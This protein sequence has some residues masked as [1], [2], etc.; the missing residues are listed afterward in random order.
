MTAHGIK[1]GCGTCTWLGSDQHSHLTPPCPDQPT[2][3]C[4]ITLKE[5]VKVSIRR[6][7]SRTAGF[8]SARGCMVVRLYADCFLLP[9]W[10]SNYSIPCASCVIARPGSL[11]ADPPPHVSSWARNSLRQHAHGSTPLP[12][13]LPVRGLGE[14]KR[15]RSR[16]W[17]RSRL[18]LGRARRPRGLRWTRQSA[19]D[20][21][22]WRICST[23]ALQWLQC[24][25]WA[26]GNEP[27]RRRVGIP[28]AATGSGTIGQSVAFPQR[29]EEDLIHLHS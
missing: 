23:V 5:A 15:A 4:R 26:A 24:E 11:Q 9:R 29:T 19:G 10:D 2:L 13:D 27:G 28:T 1:Q 7:H 21:R 22:S 3:R 8:A 12:V 6:H 17:G 16:T 18:R 25:L 20:V 14:G